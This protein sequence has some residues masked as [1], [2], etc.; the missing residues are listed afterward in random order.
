MSG[1][2]RAID[3]HD[4]KK[5]K[6]NRRREKSK[7]K[8]AEMKL[9]AEMNAVEEKERL[10]M[11]VANL[12]QELETL[13]N[14]KKSRNSI[15]FATSSVRHSVRPSIVSTRKTSGRSAAIK[16]LISTIRS[17]P[18]E[19]EAKSLRLMV[20]TQLCGTFGSIDL[21]SWE[22][23]I[24]VIRKSVNPSLSSS[25]SVLCEAKVLMLVSGHRNFPVFHG[26]IGTHQLIMEDLGCVDKEGYIVRTVQNMMGTKELCQKG[27]IMMSRQI[28]EGFIH[29]H[30]IGIIHNDIKSNNIVL[31]PTD[32]WPKYQVKI[33]DFGK[34]TLKS[35]SVI[36][37]LPPDEMEVYNIN[38]K[39][40][41]YELRNSLGS[42]QSED[43]DLYSVGY[44]IKQVGRAELFDFLIDTGEKMKTQDPKS[45]LR[46]SS[47][48]VLLKN[49]RL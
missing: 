26:V 22:R 39:Y 1:E 29:L 16:T 17:V 19:L 47:A 14:A 28:V 15:C 48:L 44:L 11:Q 34:A 2:A 6:Q 37:K 3:P 38:H 40:L 31:K 4:A 35:A 33:I 27:W 49:F 13:K 46:L 32:E 8:K 10:K 12:K 25:S 20:K 42:K 23:N 5:E 41:A 18:D 43:T 9:K 24:T 45:R 7:K 21:M 30:D 36:Y